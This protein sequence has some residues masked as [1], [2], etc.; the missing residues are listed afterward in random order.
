MYFVKCTFQ[1]ITIVNTKYQAARKISVRYQLFFLI[2]VL[3]FMLIIVLSTLSISASG[4]SLDMDPEPWQLLTLLFIISLPVVLAYAFAPQ[5]YHRTNEKNKYLSG[6]L[7]TFLCWLL[8]LFAAQFLD[9]MQSL[10]DI[11][12]TC[13]AAGMAAFLFGPLLGKRI[14][15][16]KEE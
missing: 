7:F 4:I 6:I 1:Y 13:L 15:S 12:R 5:L 14:Y 9:G 10:S 2:L 3:F 16:L 8:P 11:W